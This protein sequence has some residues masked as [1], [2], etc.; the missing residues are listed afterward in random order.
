MERRDRERGAGSGGPGGGWDG[1]GDAARPRMRVPRFV[2]EWYHEAQAGGEVTV[3][4]RPRVTAGEEQGGGAAAVASAYDLS[5][6]VDGYKL[7]ARARNLSPNTIDIVVRSVGFLRDFLAGQGL[8]TDVWHIGKGEIVAFILDLQERHRYAGHPLTPAQDRNPS[9]N[10]V[11]GYVRGVSAFFTWLATSR[12]IEVNPFDEVPIPRGEQKVIQV[13]SKE[14]LEQMLDAIETSTATGQ[15]DHAMLLLLIDTGIRSGELRDLRLG[16]VD[17]E[18]RFLTVTGKGR[19]QRMVPFAHR[20]QD[21][22]WRY[23]NFN[24]PEPALPRYDHVFLTEAGCPFSKDGLLRIVRKRGQKA[25][26]SG[27]RLSPH[28]FRHTMSVMYLKSGGPSQTLQGLLGHASAASTKRYVNMS[29]VDM[30]E[31][32]ERCSPADSLDLKSHS[33]GAKRRG[34]QPRREQ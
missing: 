24:R 21:A 3:L 12:I 34:R 7:A 11:N 33:T 23:I 15:R 29:G 1:G 18:Q 10:A 26:I 9:A 4:E 5:R 17:L 2:A 14:Q 13:F 27:I 19:V 30:A 16:D 6:L 22:L 8:S 28:T 20:A 25:G 32:H 31:I